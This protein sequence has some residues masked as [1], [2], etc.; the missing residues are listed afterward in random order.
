ML[1]MAIVSTG[2]AESI[3]VSS[4][5]AYDIY[6]KYFI[7][8]LWGHRQANSICVEGCRVFFQPIYGCPGGKCCSSWDVTKFAY[9]VLEW[10][11]AEYDSSLL[12]SSLLFRFCLIGWASTLDG[13]IFSWASWLV[14]LT[15]R[16][17]VT[18]KRP[19][20]TQFSS[21]TADKYKSAQ[22]Y[23]YPSIIEF[24]CLSSNNNQEITDMSGISRHVVKCRVV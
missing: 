24:L 3:A 20:H 17:V 1:F 14:P 16:V 21:I 10:L 15:L 2:S 12:S 13:S 9:D 11:I 6:H 7:L 8:Q 22:T 19:R 4:L 23:E 5:V 18:Q